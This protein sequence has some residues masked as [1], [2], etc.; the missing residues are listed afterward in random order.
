MPG[1]KTELDNAVARVAALLGNTAAHVLKEMIV[2]IDMSLVATS[3]FGGARTFLVTFGLI[4]L[5]VVFMMAERGTRAR[6]V[7]ISAGHRRIGRHL[8][9]VMR[10]ISHSLQRYVGVKSFVS[11]LTFA[12][13]FIPVIGLVV[14]GLVAVIGLV[15][16]NV[17]A[18]YWLE[19]L[20]SPSLAAPA[21]ALANMGLA[22]VL[23]VIASR[24]N[25]QAGLEPMTELR[26]LAIED[27]KKEVQGWVNKVRD[28]AGNVRRMAST[29][30]GPALLKHI[31]KGADGTK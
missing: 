19:T 1:Y 3:A 11:L 26:D 15:M 10:E 18:F 31:R 21:V 12:L 28:V 24:Q 30:M 4:C 14:A 29:P 17:A 25:P 2:G 13:N 6:K 27:V 5:Y 7:Q 23:A 9:E 20:W 22:G 16:L 8:P